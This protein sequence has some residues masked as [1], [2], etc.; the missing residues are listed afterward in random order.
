MAVIDDKPVWVTAITQIDPNDPVQGGKG[1]VDNV[2]HEQLADRTAYLKQEVDGIKGE[3][4]EPMTLESLLQRIKEL[5]DAPDITVPVLP[6]GATFETTLVYTSGT[7]VAAAMGYG[8]WE[9]FAEGRVTVGVS[10]NPSDPDWTKVI[11]T[12][13]GENEVV[14]TVNEM[15]SHKHSAND[16][17]NKFTGRP[18]E[19][20]S[21]YLISPGAGKTADGRADN[22]SMPNNAF[23]SGM[24]ETAWTA[25]TEQSVGNNQPHNN[26]QRSIVVGKWVRTA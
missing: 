11:G 3:T 20:T 5:E 6:V 17:F 7:E 23:I 1:G 4:T 24:N 9:P 21:E 8:T 10:S 15:P 26:V 19:V 22:I 18:D 25:M 16:I 2:P 13:F 12:E 14:L